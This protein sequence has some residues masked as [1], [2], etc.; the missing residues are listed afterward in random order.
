MDIKLAILG[1]V[2]VVGLTVIGGLTW[3]VNSLKSDLEISIK[4]TA[5]LEKSVEEQKKVIKQQKADYEEIKKLNTTLDATAKKLIQE[6]VEL[7]KKFNIKANGL[8]R[9]FGDI[10]RA[11]PK[12]V[13]KLVNRATK[14]VN[15]CFELATGAPLEEGE[16]NNECETLVSP[17]N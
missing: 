13:N 10:T 1:T 4:N 11:K 15:R 17:S 6:S 5:K 12:L 3:Y 16:K 2:G 9:D 14:N 7:H 8:S